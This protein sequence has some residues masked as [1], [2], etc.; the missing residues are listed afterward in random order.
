VQY[1]NNI[2]SEDRKASL[3]AALDDICDGLESHQAAHSDPFIESQLDL[4]RWARDQLASC[5]ALGSDD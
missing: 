5:R 2:F 1:S 3:V 4:V